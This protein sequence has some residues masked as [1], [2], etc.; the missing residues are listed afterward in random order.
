MVLT[1]LE[2]SAELEVTMPHERARLV[3]LCAR[4][5]GNIDAAEDLAQETL[6]EGWRNAHKLYDPAGRAAWHSAIARNVCLRWARRH[7]RELARSM[8]PTRQPDA[9]SPLIEDTIP[10]TFDLEAELERDELAQ[11][12]DRALGLLPPPTRA[13]LIERYVQESPIAEVALRLGLSEGAV[14]MR[15]QRGKLQLRQVLNNDLRAEAASYGL[16]DPEEQDAWTE[17]RIWCP[18]CGDHHLHGRFDPSIGELALQCRACSTCEME[19]MIY[20]RH[21]TLLTGIRGFRPALSRLVGWSYTFYQQ[22]LTTGTAPCPEC[23]KGLWVRLGVYEHA[24]P[25]LCYGVETQCMGCGQQGFSA[26]AGVVMCM[27]EVWRFWRDHPRVRLLGEQTLDVAGQAALL[28]SIESV[29]DRAR[30]DVIT[31]RDTYQLI[32]MHGDFSRG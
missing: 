1:D 22:L 14:A 15:L 25:P 12:L 32:S 27:P 28:T 29:T 20:G 2:S 8:P 19:Q 31:T 24:P 16:G 21:P 3:R 5:T 4:L 11:L 7:G 23:G 30:L 17:T 9:Q 26:H 6:I 13:V 18:L 10:D